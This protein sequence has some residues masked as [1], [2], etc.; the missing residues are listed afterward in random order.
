MTFFEDVN[1]VIP[2]SDTS[3]CPQGFDWWEEACY[4][5]DNPTIRGG[6]NLKYAE[7]YTCNVNQ[8]CYVEEFTTTFNLQISMK[9]KSKQCISGTKAKWNS[10]PFNKNGGRVM[11]GIHKYHDE[12]TIYK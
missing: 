1:G 5:A 10:I 11:K 4:I 2:C 8:D 7:V 6:N 12:L 9:C 3:D